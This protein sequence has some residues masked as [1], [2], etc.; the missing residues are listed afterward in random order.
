[1]S[2]PAHAED[3]DDAWRDAL[4]L[5]DCDLRNDRVGLRCVWRQCDQEAVTVALIMLLSR[6]IAEIDPPDGHLHAWAAD[7]MRQP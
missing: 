3:W 2:V 4:A 7:V 5:A 1:M 6:L